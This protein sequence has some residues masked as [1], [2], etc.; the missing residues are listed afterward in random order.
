MPSP[1]QSDSPAPQRW[2]FFAI[3]SVMF[4]L[5]IFIWFANRAKPRFTPP[6]T[7]AS[8]AV[9]KKQPA[10]PSSRE[11]LPGVDHPILVSSS[12]FQTAQIQ[13]ADDREI[14]SAVIDTF[15]RDF[16]GNPI[17]EN[18]EIFTALRGQNAKGLRYFPAEF[19]GLQTSGEVLDR[20]G[21]PWRFHAL[22]GKNMEIT[23]AGPDTTFGTADDLDGE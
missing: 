3:A 18:A 15:R 11:A 2:L 4:A 21:T 12:R 6:T 1:P 5:G 20:W 13:P 19:P 17:G 16:G 7:S 8:Q 14:L 23:S 22:S 10:A 9:G